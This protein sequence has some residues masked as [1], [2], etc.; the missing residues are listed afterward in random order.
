MHRSRD[1]ATRL[2]RFETEDGWMDAT[3]LT[4]M[5]EETSRLR[6]SPG[7]AALHLSHC[8]AALAPLDSSYGAGLVGGRAHRGA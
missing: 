2:W 7:D 4:E 6:G 1:I 5:V 3:E 8:A